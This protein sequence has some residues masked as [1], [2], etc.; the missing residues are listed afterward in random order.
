M[1][2]KRPPVV[3]TQATPAQILGNRYDPFKGFIIARA[4]SPNFQAS[5]EQAPF[6]AECVDDLAAAG[7]VCTGLDARG[8]LRWQTRLSSDVDMMFNDDKTYGGVPPLCELQNM[9]TGEVR[10]LFRKAGGRIG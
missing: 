2:H 10:A 1:N 9:S 7:F 6:F 5:K 4:K 3:P 8:E